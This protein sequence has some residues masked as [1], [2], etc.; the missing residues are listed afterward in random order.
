MGRALLASAALHA[1]AIVVAVLLGFVGGARRP[2]LPPVYQVQLVSA[3]QLAPQRTRPEPRPEEPVQEE[4]A[5]EPEAVEKVPEPDKPA[6]ERP[7]R[8]VREPTPRPG[9]EAAR[10]TGPD[11]PITLEGRPFEFPWYLEEI[12]R[13]VARNWRPP[14]ATLK[15]TI[16]FR[17]D[18][19]GRIEDIEVER[20]SGN[21]LFDQASLRAVQAANPMPPL[22]REYGGDWLGVYFDFDT[23]V[24]PS[25]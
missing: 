1:L 14:S 4:K 13:K 24:R 12:Y 19:T 23:Q 21:F 25:Q 22:P 7:Q 15:A 5:P 8:P 3:A 9:P 11:L 20:S 10:K 18:R 2:P 16:H 17:I 6:P